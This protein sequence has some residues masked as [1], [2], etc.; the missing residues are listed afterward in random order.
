MAATSLVKVGLAGV[1]AGDLAANMHTT[2]TKIARV[3]MTLNP[4]ETQARF[5]A[6]I[7]FL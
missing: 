1:A 2:A 4:R 3:V 7:V 6:V 5:L